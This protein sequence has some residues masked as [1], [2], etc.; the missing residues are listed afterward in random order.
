MCLVLLLFLLPWKNDLRKNMTR[1][2]VKNVM[3]NVLSWQ[4]FG[5]MFSV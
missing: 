1:I 2:Y 3:P 4:S 5:V